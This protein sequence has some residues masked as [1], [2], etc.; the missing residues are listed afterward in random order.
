MPLRYAIA[1]ASAYAVFLALLRV[2]ITWKR[3]L[4]AEIDAVDA[5]DAVS[6]LEP[7]RL[8]A[9]RPGDGTFAGGRSGGGGQSASWGESQVE[10]TSSSSSW[11][12]GDADLGWLLLAVV[13]ALA[14][15][16][17]I[18]S[19]VWTAPVLLA[20]VLVDALIVSAVSRRLADGR[21]C[22][23][24][25]DRRRRD[26]TMTAIRRTWLAAAAVIVTLTAAGWA[27][28]HLAPNAVSIGP[29]VRAIT[30]R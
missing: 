11:F 23:A 13:A 9:G 22:L 26:W 18:G 10:P 24:E 8:P 6:H 3:R 7:W 30:G 29:A 2:Y 4:E 27:L 25:A 14:G 15:V 28:Q 21:A 17:A 19:I 5:L 1:S 12:D 16:I 20:E